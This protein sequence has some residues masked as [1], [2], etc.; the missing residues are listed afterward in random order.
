MSPPLPR[1]TAP[2]DGR[3]DRM[4][5]DSTPGMPAQRLAVRCQPQHLIECQPGA[6]L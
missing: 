3:A 1:P 5:D 2:F 6:S 4:F